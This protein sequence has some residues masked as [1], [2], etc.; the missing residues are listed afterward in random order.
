V[1]LTFDDGPDPSSTPAVLD[2]LREKQVRATFFVVGNALSNTRNWYDAPWRK[3]TW[4]RTTPGA[5]RRVLFLDAR[6]AARRNREVHRNPAAHRRAQTALLPL[7]GGIAARAPAPVPARAGLEYISWQIRTRDTLNVE[8]GELT[9]RILNKIMPGDIVL[10][11]DHRAGGVDVL[12]GVLPRAIDA[13]RARG[14]HFVRVDGW[15]PSTA[16]ASDRQDEGL[17]THTGI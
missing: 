5:I 9:G 10:L 3:A 17:R 7:S 6:P 11:H 15:E 13:L 8:S 4:W 12:L 14:F 2:V 1:A 16:L